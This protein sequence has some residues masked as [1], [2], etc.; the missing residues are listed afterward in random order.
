MERCDIIILLNLWRMMCMQL[1]PIT[2]Y[3]CHV[4]LEGLVSGMDVHASFPIILI[5]TGISFAH[6]KVR[7]R[8]V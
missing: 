4:P 8:S 1:L 5:K 3:S 7:V 2:R 6:T